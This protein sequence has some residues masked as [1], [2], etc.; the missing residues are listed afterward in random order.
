MKSFSDAR[1]R[2]P[3]PRAGRPNASRPLAPLLAVPLV[4]LYPVVPSASADEP[5]P[6]PLPLRRI[7][8]PPDRVAGELERA[9]QGTLIRLSR[10]E[11]EERVRQ[12]AQAR[13]FLQNPP[14]LVEAYYRGKLD[15][16]ALLGTGQWKI[17]NPGPAGGVLPLQ[18]LNLAVQRVR[19]QK[20][21]T[22]PSDAVL[23]D[24][25][26]KGLALL[27]EQGGEQ[28]AFLDW[29]ARGE[30]EAAGLRF[31]LQV[32]ACPCASLELNVPADEV[33]SSDP[34]TC[35]VVGPD[36]AEA[37]DR[38]SWRV[39][40]ANRTGLSLTIR[41][42]ASAGSV[43]PPILAE[44]QTT[45]ELGLDMLQA[46]YE[47]R[48]EVPQAGVSEIALEYDSALHP[49]EVEGPSLE[50]WEARPPRPPAARGDLAVR[51]RE[52]FRGGV[53]RVRCRAP[54]GPD[55]RWTCPGVRLPGAIDRGESLRLR[56]PSDVQLAQ[57]Q[58]GDF[59][60]TANRGSEDGWQL[61]S[62]T[63]HA[64]ASGPAIR[65][66]SA[67][68]QA[69]FPEV[70]A[71][72]T[73][74]WQLG[75]GL[76][77]LTVQIQYEAVRGQLLTLPVSLPRGWVVTELT[78]SAPVHL[79][80]W[81]VSP[82][83]DHDVLTVDLKGALSPPSAG[84]V[85]ASSLPVLTVRLR[86]EGL[87]HG[88]LDRPVPFPRVAPQ[89]V[90]LR[91]NNLAI[92]IAPPWEG[93]VQS[94]LPIQSAPERNPWGRQSVAYFYSSPDEPLDGTLRLRT[95]Q[96]RLRARCR[97]E[98]VLASG[99][100]AV[101]ARLFLEPEATNSA[102]FD[103][104]LSTPLGDPAVQWRTR[105]GANRV[106]EFRRLWGPEVAG[107]LGPLGV[108][109]ALGAAVAS[110][111]SQGGAR[112]RVT[113]AR[114][115]REPVVL[116][117][118][119]DL[120]GQ[121]EIQG[122][123]ER[124][125][126][127]GRP[128]SAPPTA[129]AK[130]RWWRVPLPIVL[131]ADGLDGDVALYLGTTEFVQVQARGLKSVAAG[132]PSPSG[133]P[134]QTLRYDRRPLA[135]ILR[136]PVAV[137]DETGWGEVKHA[138]LTTFIDQGGRLLHHYG[139]QIC[140]W[141][142]QNLPVRFPPG[143]QAVA[144]K[145]DGR[146]VT[147]MSLRPLEEAKSMVTL[148]VPG[149]GACHR[150]EVVYTTEQK[151]WSLWAD[152]VPMRPDDAADGAPQPWEPELPVRPTTFRHTWRLPAGVVPLW[153][154]R[155]NKLPGSSAAV[156]S[157]ADVIGGW[158]RLSGP[159]L[160]WESVRSDGGSQEQQQFLA[161]AAGAWPRGDQPGPDV[162]LADF[163]E[164]LLSAPASGFVP[165]VVD[166]QAL[167]RGGW[168][169]SSPLPRLPSSESP[170]EPWESLG[171]TFVPGAPGLLL[172]TRVQAESWRALGR[173]H[174][175]LP[176]S[177]TEAVSAAAQRGHDK[178][179]R[180][181]DVAGWLAATHGRTSEDPAFW[182]AGILP[183]YCGGD[184]TEWE[185]LA[186]C[187]PGTALVVVRE[188]T[189]SRLGEAAAVLL[190]LA[191]W[192]S[193]RLP[194]V[195]R[196]GWLLTWVTLGMLGCCWLQG[197]LLALVKWPAFAGVGVAVFWYS[198]WVLDYRGN[199]KTK[200]GAAL[201]G[202]GIL[203]AW[204]VPAGRAA[205]P[206]PASVLIL[207]T[208]KRPPAEQTVLVPPPLLDQLQSMARRGRQLLS[209]PVLV[210]G[211]YEGTVR[212]AAAE[213]S[214]EFEV[215]SPSEEAATLFVPL[216]AEVQLKEGLLDGAPAF[217]RHVR[218]DRPPLSE[219]YNLDVKG[220]GFHTLRIGFAVAVT[221][222]GDDRD[223][224]FG[225][226]ELAQ[227]R[228]GLDFPPGT[229]LHQTVI[230]RGAS[231]VA[232]DG[233]A[234]SP[235]SVMGTR[236]ETDLGRVGTVH[237]R[238]RQ[239]VPSPAPQAAVREAHLW[240][241]QPSGATLSTVVQY[242]VARG[243]LTTLAV[244]VP[245]DLQVARVGVGRLPGDRSGEAVPR[246]QNW[247]MGGTARAPRLEVELQR[248]ATGGVQLMLELWLRQPFNGSTALP[249]PA[250]VGAATQDGPSKESF[251]AYRAEGVVAQVTDHL[252]I[253]GADRQPFA[254]F[255]RS[256]KM[257]EPGAQ[258]RV[259][260]FRRALG[261]PV[262]RLALQAFP[263]A[264]RAVQRVR[265]TLGLRRADFQLTARVTAPGRDLVLVEWE[266]PAA[267]HVGEVRGDE[268]RDWSRSG[269]CLQVWLRR[270]VALATVQVLGWR[271]W[272]SGPSGGASPQALVV[273]PVRLISAPV[274]VTYLAVAGDQNL[275]LEPTRLLHL[276]PLPSPR[277]SDLEYVTQRDDF[278][279]V[280]RA[281]SRQAEPESGVLTLVEIVE[282]RLTLHAV[283]NLPTKPGHSDTWTIRVRN[284]RGKDIRL[285]TPDPISQ[286]NAQEGGLYSWTLGPLPAETGPHQVRLA[287]NRPLQPGTTFR[288]PEVVVE[289]PVPLERWLA[290]AGGGLRVDDPRGLKPVAD[291]VRAL[292]RWPGEA[293]RVRRAGSAW[294][295]PSRDGQL[296][297]R[298]ESLAG[299]A[300]PVRIVL[301]E[302]TLGVADG[303]H[304]IHRATFH[305]FQEGG[306]DLTF[307]LPRGARV[308]A[309]AVDGVE[310]RGLQPE[311]GR[312]WLPLPGPAGT[313][314]VSLTW[315][316]DEGVETLSQPLLGGAELE[317]ATESTTLWTAY[318]PAGYRCTDLPNHGS[319]S[320]PAEAD[321]ERAEA[322]LSLSERLADRLDGGEDETIRPQLAAAQEEFYRWC[323]RASLRTGKPASLD[324]L[325]RE[326]ETRNQTLAKDK[327]FEALRSQAE[328]QAALHPA[329]AP[330][331]VVPV[332]PGAYHRDDRVELDEPPRQ[333]TPVYWKTAGPPAAPAL[334]L[335]ALREEQDRRAL[336]VSGV[337]LALI[338]A[339]W[340]LSFFP[341][342]GAW[343]R[344][345]WP[346]QVLAAALLGWLLA[347]GNDL[348]VLLGLA[349]LTAR[350]TITGWWLARLRRRPRLNDGK[351]VVAS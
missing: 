161:A 193:R 57:W 158:G 245:P 100:A 6:D 337:L 98:V 262:L 83:K 61:V 253:T 336:I 79:R 327:G 317:G 99:R 324:N 273:S 20:P 299:S 11:F 213:L 322:H 247:F 321:L 189:L 53:V 128:A 313:R 275:N 117:A 256:A 301:A 122:D 271:S 65:R 218:K 167:G 351:A 131:S 332:P 266:V 209:R 39:S 127:G 146:W 270:P 145:V 297:L 144:A 157:V 12:A 298:C 48:L 238:W 211:R 312:L 109:S 124:A 89:G 8:V 183:A 200:A 232:S 288:M 139:F 153:E 282:G 49:Y 111:A 276:W 236:L 197:A 187:E 96:P 136:A 103:L 42:K 258:T 300:R 32:P 222:K 34:A 260:A 185:A 129:R 309:A 175:L 318:V 230:H 344:A 182:P 88:I 36:P 140:N 279:A 307:R 243:A 29:S 165:V 70:S 33:V 308:R 196:L 219:G 130:D 148:P 210:S 50:T 10:G 44:L 280:F 94:R 118:S 302:R 291:P 149:P 216:G 47:F 198:W 13:L 43:A 60:F 215:F 40:F 331:E 119:F 71:R 338:L 58:S 194:R 195:I 74:W 214:V 335:V 264:T 152:I 267:I 201:V 76:S 28:V 31:D 114:P 35:L 227:N 191:A 251:L 54:L 192:A 82:E 350:G 281:G 320:S 325:R 110:G 259:Y 310:V 7:V 22:E 21:P 311:P 229:F 277:A 87:N 225:V 181:R 67:R 306:A 173:G 104:F 169:P 52:T 334:T 237:V 93:D 268:V 342:A 242:T 178:S 72:Q 339:V 62:L 5:L 204:A 97:S 330:R 249:L 223:L 133:L 224:K 234:E 284:W 81:T 202:G 323:H 85:P 159:M 180:F 66:P 263:S 91:E 24:V 16:G 134:R 141:R 295:I 220:R 231:R 248:P 228:L 207:P 155:Y 73:A 328:Q 55:Q 80:S 160:P 23:G 239:G 217:L 75:P 138:H 123:A 186:G 112:Y 278:E 168:G 14:R 121:E 346:E 347:G 254:D 319:W 166:C 156:S 172:T 162:R 174:G 294:Q 283:V 106:Q 293:E 188:D 184:W 250:P 120:A 77:A 164:R 289:G 199:R 304:W 3:A 63:R 285:E 190:I 154:G 265:W 179:D 252:R 329:T 84:P 314:T 38:C 19:L 41:R 326:L 37:P 102:A 255:W 151:A 15:K 208:T 147:N 240:V 272:G 303:R 316:F 269:S 18:P 348:F 68:L 203:L 261:P 340:G 163:L 221:P 205:P 305:L 274:D 343:A 101:V 51:F 46:D 212:S 69:R 2:E 286:A 56:V 233:T 257:G 113:L 171:L 176:H 125:L 9:R 92:S 170:A 143:S 333:G 86:Q 45:Q 244:E 142:Q 241:V 137:A 132:G 345:F 95:R 4:F 1:F 150:C 226:P 78:L 246:I 27:T 296:W 116:E 90:W 64:R 287:G 206:P 59:H 126:D 177:V 292:R 235:G 25:D 108:S 30:A 315:Q 17:L 105:S 135:L 107:W 341:T 290:V 115:L 26:G 349:G